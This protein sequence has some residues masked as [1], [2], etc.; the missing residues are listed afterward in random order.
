MTDVINDQV[1]TYHRRRAA[2]FMRLKEAHGNLSNMAFGYPLVVNDVVFSSSEGL[3]QALKFPHAPDFQRHIAVQPSGM[4]AKSAA[5]ERQDIRPDWD[6]MRVAAMKY[7]V[8]AKLVQHPER[9]HAALQGTQHLPIVERANKD[10]YWGAKPAFRDHT[11]LMGTNMLGKLLTALRESLRRHR[12]DVG[13]A[14]ADYLTGVPLENLRVN[15]RPVPA[16]AR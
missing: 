10:P 7:A 11:S 4:A 3:Y 15:G 16:G 14:V 12:G 9:F 5:Y 2:V 1:Q 6:E 8:A 13:D